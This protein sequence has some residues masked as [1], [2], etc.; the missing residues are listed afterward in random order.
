MDDFDTLQTQTMERRRPRRPRRL[1]AGRDSEFIEVLRDLQEL[2][3]EQLERFDR[4]RVEWRD[5]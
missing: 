1:V 2:T 5:G 3:P 4:L